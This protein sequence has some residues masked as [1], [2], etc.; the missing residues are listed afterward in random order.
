M[1]SKII[2]SGQLP[3]FRHNFVLGGEAIDAFFGELVK[4]ANV[5]ADTA[6]LAQRVAA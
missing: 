4:I 3:D 6:R 5:N 2:E 1:L